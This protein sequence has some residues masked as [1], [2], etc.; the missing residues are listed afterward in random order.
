[1]EEDFDA[2]HNDVPLIDTIGIPNLLNLATILG[3]DCA[4]TFA[5]STRPLALYLIIIRLLAMLAPYFLVVVL[6]LPRVCFGF[7]AERIDSA[8][9]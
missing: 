5:W 3:T 4:R 7:N 6:A 1:M 9:V 2:S 8:S